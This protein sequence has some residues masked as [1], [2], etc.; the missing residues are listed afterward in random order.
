MYSNSEEVLTLS[1]KSPGTIVIS[2]PLIGHHH[3]RFSDSYEVVYSDKKVM[4]QEEFNESIQEACAAI[5]M[6]SI[7][8]S[9][10][11]I[12]SAPN[13]KIL[14]NCGVGYDNIEHQYARDKGILVTNTP[15]VLTTS[16]AEL[17]VALVMATA[18]RLAEGFRLIENNEFSG[19]KIDLLLGSELCGKT[20]GIFGCGR[21]GQAMVRIIK[22]FGMNIIYHNRRRLSS[23]MEAD[24]GMRYVGF[25]DL[26]S[27]SD[28]LVVTASLNRD[29][30][31]SFTLDNFRKM[32]RGSM[33]VNIGR[34]G[35]IKE[36]DLILALGE[37]L[38]AAVGLDVFETPHDIPLELKTDPRVTLTPHIG[39]AT[40]E[41]RES[42][43][44]LAVDAVIDALCGTKP[45]YV[46][47]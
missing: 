25:K 9:P 6:T 21:I 12:D 24:L 13:L 5:V 7:T 20:L 14:S 46:V 27:L 40:L 16:C 43:S 10:Q 45:Q 42:M 33:L 38:I 19:W 44:A 34:G 1:E 23:E 30:S 18:R 35:I 39:S 26:I 28:V 22:G 8:V 37:D 41:A 29:N 47:N 2:G 15:D 17:G 3:K 31:H 36:S 11:V 32:K 4:H